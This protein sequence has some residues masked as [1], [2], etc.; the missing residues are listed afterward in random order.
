[1]LDVAGVG[2]PEHPQ[3][4]V[5]GGVCRADGGHRGA[6]PKHRP[7]RRFENKNANVSLTSLK[8]TTL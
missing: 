2:G 5:E 8:G 7:R 6:E 3:A 4:G 1:V